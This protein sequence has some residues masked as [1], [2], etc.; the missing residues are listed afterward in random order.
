M[1]IKFLNKALLLEI[2]GKNIFVIADLHIGYEESL[3]K[4]GILVPRQQFKQMFFELKEI[5][6]DLDKNDEKKK[7]KIDEI[8]LLGDLKHEF[9]EISQQEWH[10]TLKILDFFEKKLGKEKG[11]GKIVLVRGNHDTILEPI[12]RKKKIKILEIYCVDRICFL[13]GDRIFPECLGREIK[14]L[15]LGHRHPAVTLSD[16]YKKEKYKCFLIGKWKKKEII[17]LPSF[18]PF[19]EGSDVINLGGNRMFISEKEMKN[20]QVKVLGEDRK[21]YDFKSLKNISENIN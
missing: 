2:G 11:K 1:K 7:I 14:T 18:L 3:N 4:K 17:I 12:A 15:V 20:F 8:V 21:I 13:H 5:F 19:I 6:K 16:K 10:E 9:G